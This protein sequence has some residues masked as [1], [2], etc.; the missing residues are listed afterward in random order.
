[1]KPAG[2]RGWRKTSHGETRLSK[3]PGCTRSL[4]SWLTGGPLGLWKLV[5]RGIQQ[6]VN[7]SRESSVGSAEE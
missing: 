1:M 3:L 2:E 6:L 4:C 7:L 5:A